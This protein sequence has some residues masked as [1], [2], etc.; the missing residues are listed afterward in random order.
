MQITEGHLGNQCTTVSTHTTDGFCSPYR[1]ACE[2]VIVFVDTRETNHTQFHNEMIYEFLDLFFGVC[3]IAKVAFR[4]DVE[5]CRV[6]ADGHSSTVLL[7]NRAKV[8]EVNPLHSFFNVFSWPRN[9][10]TIR[11]SHFF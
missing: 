8:A 11:R 6:T 4:V 7:F 3:A 2:Q 5:E 10:V 9:I 1:I